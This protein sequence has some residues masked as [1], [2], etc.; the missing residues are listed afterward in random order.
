MNS[1][2][3]PPGLN[4]MS[5]AAV[6]MGVS[7]SAVVVGVSSSAVVVGASSSAVVVVVVGV[8]GTACLPARRVPCDGRDGVGDM[9]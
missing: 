2:A 8:V 6:V 3:V 5:S 4:G 7:S 1:T 9:R